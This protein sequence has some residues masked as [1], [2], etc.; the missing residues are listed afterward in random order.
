M[1][2]AVRDR[3]GQVESSHPVPRRP[4]DP[5]LVQCLAMRPARVR[6]RQTHL[7]ESQRVGDRLSR[8][9]RIACP[10]M[11]WYG[12]CGGYGVWYVVWIPLCPGRDDT[13]LGPMLGA[14]SCRWREGGVWRMR[15]REGEE[16]GSSSS[17]LTAISLYST[18]LYGTVHTVCILPT[19]PT[20]TT[21]SARERQQTPRV[22]W[23][24]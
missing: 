17:N 2:I 11:A 8:T 4:R 15:S 21:P 16:P 10:R 19:R 5:H 7:S 13:G 23:L 20:R 14:R 3:T 22:N 1:P 6:R 18:V 24:L 9:V 12:W